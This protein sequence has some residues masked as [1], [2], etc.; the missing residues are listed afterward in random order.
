M[1]FSTAF[2]EQ[3]YGTVAEMD[4]CDRIDMLHLRDYFAAHLQVDDRLVKVIRAM[5]DTAL[6]IYALHPGLE[7]EEW[8]TEIETTCW[9]A[10][11]S[12]VAKIARRLELEARAIARVRYLQADAMM[13]ERCIAHPKTKV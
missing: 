12:Q 7:R 1:G 5:D 8:I 11:P 9:D 2:R 3:Y 10:L 6:E 4:E 13:V